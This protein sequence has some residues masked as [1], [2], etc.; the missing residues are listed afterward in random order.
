MKQLRFLV[1]LLVIFTSNTIKSQQVGEWRIYKS[2]HNATQNVA[3]GSNIY[4]LSYGSLY[5]YDNEDKSITTYDKTNLLNDDQIAH[6][7]YNNLLKTLVIIYENSNI[8]LFINEKEIY[9]LPDL[10][11]KSIT[12]KK[13]NSVFS[14]DEYLY[15]STDFGIVI[16]NIK[17]KEITNSYVLNKKVNGIVIQNNVIY[18]ATDKGI[19]TGKLTDNLLDNSMWKT[20][21]P[22]IFNQIMLY[23]DKILGNNGNS[24]QIINSSDGSTTKL[25]DG[26]FTFYNVSDGKLMVGNEN[27]LVI[28]NGNLQSYYKI[29]QNEN[30]QSL[31]Y[32]KSKDMYWGSNG[33]RGL[34]GYKYNK[35]NNTLENVVQSILPESPIRNLFEY[36]NF[37]NGYLLV[38]GG[39]INQDRYSNPG[40]IMTYKD[41]NWSS[42]QE[43]GISEQ[44]G[45]RYM[46]ITSV[47]EDPR[48]P[49]HFFA[50]SAGEGVYEFKDNKFVKLYSIGNS[51]LTSIYPK[52][53][54][55]ANYLEYLRVNG[56]VYDKN[57]NLWALS[58][59]VENIINVLK[60]DN[61]WV[62]L[63]YP[64][65]SKKALVK[66]LMF[67]SRG[68]GWLCASSWKE[69]GLF[70]FDTNGTLENTRDDKTKLYSNFT[71][72]DGTQLGS[73]SIFCAVE[74][75]NG[76][77]WIGT[78][79][80]PL[81]VNNPSKV[82][83]SNFYFTQIKV[84]RN[85]GT[86][87][88]DFLLDKEK[89]NT[90]CIDGANRKWIG[91]EAGGAYLIS[92]DGLETIH[93]FNMDNSPVPSN[94]IMSITIDPESGIVY[95]GT[96]AGL[97]TYR[98]DATEGNESFSEEAHAFPNPVKPDYNGYITVTGL[99]K[100]S[101]V[102][103]TD[104]N[105][106]L[107]CTGTSLGG[108]F[109]WNG[110]NSSGKRVASGVYFVLATNK[111]GKEG[112]VTKILMI[113]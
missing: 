85:D 14:K 60:N 112:I 19:L 34:M 47:V 68:W 69:P 80:G 28:F 91:T 105:G 83:D 5:S 110:K 7:S 88:A 62:S 10:M 32:N 41:G 107:I 6:I 102:K 16:L 103:I 104:S 3:V 35:D 78:D 50:S 45:L 90:I 49:T 24:I 43:K 111:E 113:K 42:F 94:N 55:K 95:F 76:A 59:Q 109:S 77:V 58:S 9:N 36:M 1:F 46:D 38:A 20:L 26:Y 4:V 63:D 92:E 56:L 97:A 82:F 44:T 22:V 67:D 100:D 15:L 8:D 65:I 54:D 87:N 61:K 73:L 23:D 86:N 57:N 93:H 81:V 39:G 25:T 74:D 108:Q 21:T 31:S 52:D 11:N 96:E 64:E 70:C 75:K 30:F 84:P 27:S 37:N 99:V 106:N 98:S 71:N 40:T 53:Y 51:T 2:Y 12:G 33:N 66:Q 17:K 72:Q 29:S 79:S 48:D 18:A 13:L 89:I 101:D